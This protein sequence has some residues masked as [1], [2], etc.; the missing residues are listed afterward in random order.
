M[1]DWN[2][3]KPT[4][5]LASYVT[6]FDAGRA[7]GKEIGVQNALGRYKADPMGAADELMKYDPE[8]GTRLRKDAQAQAD[9]KR[10]QGYGAQFGQ[11][12]KAAIKAATEAGDLDIAAQLDTMNDEQ[13]AAVTEQAQTIAAVGQKLATMP[14]EERVKAMQTLGPA[15]V[16]RGFPQ[17]QIATFDPTDENIQAALL[18]VADLQ[19]AIEPKIYKE[20]RK[21]VGLNPQTGEEMFDY[22]IEAD[23]LDVEYRRAQ[24]NRLNRPPAA[25]GSS[26]GGNPSAAD[27]DVNEIEWD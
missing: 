10:R 19:K 17:E 22:E 13:I 26:G 24:I 2:A 9:T 23:P 21:I 8:L 14:Y 18:S 4:N 12:P 6:A 25:R 5:A 1:I 3:I 11:D 7:R 27:I 20:G 16:A 15:L